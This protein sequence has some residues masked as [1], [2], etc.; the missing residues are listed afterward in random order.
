MKSGDQTISLPFD[1][2]GTAE[3]DAACFAVLGHSTLL[4]VDKE[5]VLFVVA[6]CFVICLCHARRRIKSEGKRQHCT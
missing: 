1:T 4:S 3:L 2:T 5:T 6:M